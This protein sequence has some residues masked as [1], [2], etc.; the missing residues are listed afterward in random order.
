MTVSSGRASSGARSMLRAAYCG[1][2]AI[3]GLIAGGCGNNTLNYGTVVITVSSDP[4]PFNAYVADI[5]AITFVRSDGSGYGLSFSSGYGKTVDFTRLADTPEVLGAP[6]LVENTYTSATI[7]M[8][9]GSWANYYGGQIYVNGQT[10]AAT[11]V[12]STGAAAGSISYTVK[13]DPAHPLVVKKGTPTTLDLH[14]DMSASTIVDASASPVKATVRPFLTA[15]TQPVITKP[16]RARGEF[17]AANTGGSNFSVNTVAFFDSPL[18]SNVPAG[19]VQIQTTPDTTYNVNGS[20]YRGADGLTALSSLSIN[21]VITSYGSFTDLT[22][23]KPVFT[24]TEVYAGVAT[25]NVLA[26]RVTGTV[27]SRTANTLHLH[28]VGVVA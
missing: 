26:G 4:G 21:T 14:F 10:T 11:L 27:A 22:P 15:S 1:V 25:E 23:Q 7:T 3:V 8:H 6:A 12:D 19:A 20:V 13:F 16:L 9:F 18:V 28:N 24:A 5:A 2:L 17:V